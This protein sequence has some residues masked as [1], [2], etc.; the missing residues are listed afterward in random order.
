M[1]HLHRFLCTCLIR[2]KDE[3]K[4]TSSTLTADSCSSASTASLQP[5]MKTAVRYWKTGERSCAKKANT[6]LIMTVEPPVS[7]HPPTRPKIYRAKLG[8][9][10]VQHYIHV[11][12]DIL[13]F[14]SI[15]PWSQECRLI[16]ETYSSLSRHSVSGRIPSRK[17]VRGMGR[18]G[19][20]KSC[21]PLV[22]HLQLQA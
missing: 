16:P 19:E 10:V 9:D 14:V 3:T 7:G 2:L 21:S 4:Q 6:L 11:T 12:K 13:S 18:G 1:I 17:N 5:V 15:L 8:K 20:G 22:E